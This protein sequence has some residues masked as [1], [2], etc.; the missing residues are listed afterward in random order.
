MIKKHCDLLLTN[1]TLVTVDEEFRILD[2]GCIAISGELIVAVG[3]QELASDYEAEVTMDCTN[4]C[5]LPGFVDCHSHFGE[6]LARGVGEGMPLWPWLSEFMLPMVNLLDREDMLAA[7]QLAVVEA[8][9]NGVTSVL[10]CHG[11]PDDPETVLAIADTSEQIGMRGFIGAPMRE[12]YLPEGTAESE[13]QEILSSYSAERV[14]ESTR[15]IMAARTGERKMQIC[16]YVV[17]IVC[18]H[19]ALHRG[20]SQL[21]REF[22]TPWQTHCSEARIEVE[23]FQDKYGMRPVEW[24]HREELL[25]P[26]ATLAHGI[27]YSDQEIEYLGASGAAIAYNSVSNAYLASGTLRY[28]EL[29]KAGVL[30]GLGSDGNS[31]GHQDMFEVMRQ[32]IFLQRVKTLDAE[33]INADQVLAMA[34]RDGARMLGINAGV[35]AAGKLA[36]LIVIDMEAS[37][38]YPRHQV[39]GNLVYHARG[40]DVETTIS[41]G[42]VVF[43]KG[44]CL[45]ADEARIKA[46]VQERASALIER[47]ELHRFSS[48]RHQ[49]G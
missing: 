19:L 45:F 48:L 30:L 5:I 44:I 28:P 46:E 4:K 14:I 3:G 12:P 2:P 47:G 13:R 35:I 16:P 40:S 24:L 27:W 17:N 26:E 6:S 38:F 41:G 36:D 15:Q 37:H 8:V 33:V 1:A 32:A 49:E 29:K 22:G 42:E 23:I 43:D 25:G 20:A 11:L 21:A 31:C 39:T 7:T 9:R 18:D 10:N 34:T